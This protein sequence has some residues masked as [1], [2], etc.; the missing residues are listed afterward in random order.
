M[1]IEAIKRRVCLHAQ[2]A[3]WREAN[4]RLSFKIRRMNRFLLFETMAW[5]Q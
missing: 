4:Q 3:H 5:R 1:N 2:E